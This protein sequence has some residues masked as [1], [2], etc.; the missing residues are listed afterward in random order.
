MR[1]SIPLLI[2]LFALASCAEL[3]SGPQ[4][5]EPAGPL[6]IESATAFA[7]GCIRGEADHRLEGGALFLICVPEQW[8]GDLVLYAPGYVSPFEPLRIRDDELTDDGTRVSDLVL[9][10]GYAFATTS[11]RDNGL[12]VPEE[13]I[14]GD[15]LNLVALFRETVQPYQPRHTYLVGASQ[16]G[17][18]TVL[19]IERYPRLSGQGVFSGGLA[20]CGPYGDY[21]RHTDYLGD[22]RVIFDYFFAA[23]LPGW[24]VW[25]SSAGTVDQGLIDA[26][27]LNP[28]GVE[29]G[30][31]RVIATNPL[32]TTQL[33]S[34]TR[35]PLDPTRPA[36]SAQQT[37][38]EALWYHTFSTNDALAKLGGMPFDNS[39]RRYSGSFNDFALNRNVQRFRADAA[40]LERIQT[41]YET[42]G[43][44]AAPLVT[45]HTTFDPA[46]PAWHQLLYAQKA[47]PWFLHTAIP[48]LRYGHCDFRVQEVLAAFA[49]LVLKVSAQE[50]LVTQQTLPSAEARGEFLRMARQ[51][52]ANPRFRRR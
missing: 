36:S 17:H 39:R 8:N 33:Y 51:H 38:V 29:G 49:V 25:T 23:R 14:A 31:R 5:A 11:F 15:L 42:T 40:A 50:L 12:I 24:P 21:R 9:G 7:G 27:R 43:K 18:A 34:V 16:G 3:P 52:G 32:R 1:R 26:W 48:V 20:A 35:A 10:L 13:W 45:L 4:P 47:S 41:K 30:I 46:V 37:A 28:H 2:L 44:L 6:L 19:G 22:F